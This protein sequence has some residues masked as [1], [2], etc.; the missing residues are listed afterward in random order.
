MT[1][2]DCSGVAYCL[3]FKSVDANLIS[4]LYLKHDI[5]E[6]YTQ[7]SRNSWGGVVM[8]VVRFMLAVTVN[9]N[10]YPPFVSCIMVRSLYLLHNCE[11]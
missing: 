8:V 9:H 7:L 4:L 6:W 3:M 11:H 2:M 10:E 1:R 5:L